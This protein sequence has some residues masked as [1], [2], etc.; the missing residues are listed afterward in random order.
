MDYF[1][2]VDDAMGLFIGLACHKGSMYM[3][4]R[5]MYNGN[6]EGQVRTYNMKTH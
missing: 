3:V 1:A 5:Q 4:T 6:F 2:I